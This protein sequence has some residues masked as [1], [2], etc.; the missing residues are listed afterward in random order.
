MNKLYTF[1]FIESERLEMYH[2]M[3]NEG[4]SFSCQAK[5]LNEAVVNF[6]RNQEEVTMLI[7][8]EK[9]VMK[10]YL[11]ANAK[12]NQM[13]V[14]TELT[15]HPNEFQTYYV[16][17]ESCITYCLKELRAMIA[18]AD[19]FDLPLNAAYGAANEPIYFTVRYPQENHFFTLLWMQ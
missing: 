7:S 3:T 14:H 6:L 13:A 9:F 4:N 12:E 8:P 2:E 5:V 1:P 18:L 11:S 15:M 16:N 17:S 19:H 10:N